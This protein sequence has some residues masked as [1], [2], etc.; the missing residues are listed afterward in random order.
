ME[1]PRCEQ[2]PRGSGVLGVQESRDGLVLINPP[3][4]LGRSPH[5]VPTSTHTHTHTHIRLLLPLRGL[6]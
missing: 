4:T 3:P 1:S 5:I 2:K 6:Q